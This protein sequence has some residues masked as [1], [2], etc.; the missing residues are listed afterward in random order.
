MGDMLNTIKT[1]INISVSSI[2]IIIALLIIIVNI[3]NENNKKAS[4]NLILNYELY[5]A[6]ILHSVT[7]F[8]SNQKDSLK[9][10]CSVLQSI[11]FEFIMCIIASI[12]ITAYHNYTKP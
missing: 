10:I 4:V 12:S 8:I 7:F 11:S 3:K 6:F 9:S 1:I 5:V 2:I